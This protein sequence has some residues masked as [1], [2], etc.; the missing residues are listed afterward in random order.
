MQMN[1]YICNMPAFLRLQLNRSLHSF[2]LIKQRPVVLWLS[3][4]LEQ[5]YVFVFT[6]MLVELYCT[7]VSQ[8]NVAV[9]YIF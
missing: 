3:C 4:S 2:S 9:T 5:L 6:S 8:K 1:A 7:D